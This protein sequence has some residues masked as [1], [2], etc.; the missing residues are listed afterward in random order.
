MVDRGFVIESIF[1]FKSVEFVIL[2]FK[3]QGCLQLIEIEG[4]MFEKIVEVRIYVERVM[5]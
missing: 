3:G 4:K 1:Y 2:D 5:Q